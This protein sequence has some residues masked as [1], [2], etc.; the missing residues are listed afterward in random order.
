MAGMI[1]V[2]LWQA[3]KADAAAE[4]GGISIPDPLELENGTPVASPEIWEQQRRPELLKLF[5][6]EVYGQSPALP[7]NQTYDVE[8]ANGA[9]FVTINSTG[10]NGQFSFRLKLFLP[11]GKAKGTFVVID[12]RGSASDDP[13]QDGDY[14]PA[15]TITSAGYAA[16]TFNAS[17]VAEDGGGYANGAL[18]AFGQGNDGAKAIGAWAWAA[19]RAMDYLQ[20]D[21]DIDPATVAVIG[22]S[23]S[24]KAALWA[25]AQDT[26]FAAVISNNSGSTGAKLARKSGGEDVAAINGQFPHW[27][28]DKYSTYNGNEEAMP[29]DQH[30]L[31]ALVAPRRVVVASATDDATANPEGEFLSYLAA[32][33][34]YALY[35]LADNGLTSE[36]F[37][38]ATGRDFRG[39]A[40]SYHLRSGGHGLTKDDWAMYLNGDIFSN[41]LAAPIVPAQAKAP[42]SVVRSGGQVPPR[43]PKPVVSPATRP[44]GLVAP[45]EAGRTGA[46]TAVP[47]RQ[48]VTAPP[49][50]NGRVVAPWHR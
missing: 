29:V 40:M 30:E 44:G 45:W 16:A 24:G 42:Q 43:G 31:M 37:P 9:R 14:F 35:G 17:E 5:Q 41:G 26:R 12:H 27:F 22:H 18:K 7:T 19:S 21:A 15:K 28:A 33:P 38:P 20:T 13:S 23:R 50:Q 8:E 1:S 25:G 48:S 6:S 34:V 11:N 2:G 36:S 4:V 49:I 3:P 47:A 39:D 10:P 32:T 46:S